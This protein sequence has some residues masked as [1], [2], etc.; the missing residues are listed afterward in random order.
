MVVPSFLWVLVIWRIHLTTRTK[1]LDYS[2]NIIRHNPW[3]NSLSS[4]FAIFLDIFQRT[5]TI[6]LGVT[7]GFIFIKSPL[8]KYRGHFIQIT[9]SIITPFLII[10]SF[11]RITNDSN[12]IYPVFGAILV[13]LVGIVTPRILYRLKGSKVSDAA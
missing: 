5:L 9:I 13:T 2:I 11:L 8:R 1:K 3:L 10:I 4:E 12:W 7:L 6:Y